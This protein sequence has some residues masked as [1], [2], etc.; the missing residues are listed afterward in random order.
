M[1]PQF[2]VI[3]FKEPKPAK[4]YKD[5][6]QDSLSLYK[7]SAPDGHISLTPFFTTAKSKDSFE[8]G[9]VRNPEYDEFLNLR[10]NDRSFN[11]RNLVASKVVPTLLDSF[12]GKADQAINIKAVELKINQFTEAEAQR[13]ITEKTQEY[14][15]LGAKDLINNGHLMT[16]DEFT[17]GFR[18]VQPNANNRPIQV[19]HPRWYKMFPPNKNS[20]PLSTKEEQTAISAGNA[21]PEFSIKLPAIPLQ[22][23][24]LKF[25]NPKDL[26]NAALDVFEYH[27]DKEQTPVQAL[28]NHSSFQDLDKQDLLDSLD[29]LDG[30]NDD[31]VDT[32]EARKTV[33]NSNVQDLQ[34]SLVAS[35]EKK[36]NEQASKLNSADYQSDLNGFCKVYCRYNET[37]EKA[38]RNGLEPKQPE[39]PNKT[40]IERIIR[41]AHKKW[42]E[43]LEKY[44]NSPLTE[45][46]METIIRA[47]KYSGLSLK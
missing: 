12:D 47:A 34:K 42:T 29:I 16:P 9:F 21:Y 35:F 25:A 2:K 24:E 45:A 32:K 6:L 1:P 30:K 17:E 15:N 14:V 38:K 5:L 33:S 18:D 44:K 27:L 43:L 41:D 40:I 7:Q 8:Q 11:Y 31:R 10:R 39:L 36:I 46:E 19:P 22:Q 4:G 37:L 28:S 3:T 26:L 20:S 13:L 23:P